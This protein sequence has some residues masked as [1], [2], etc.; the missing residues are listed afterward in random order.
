MLLVS[1][2]RGATYGGRIYFVGVLS[3]L[4]TCKRAN[5]PP[6]K[7]LPY[8]EGWVTC[9]DMCKWRAR[10]FFATGSTRQG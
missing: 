2:D 5:M 9:V 3:Y 1:V 8:L 7:Y 4:C 10:S 6:A